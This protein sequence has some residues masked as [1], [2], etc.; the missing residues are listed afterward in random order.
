MKRLFKLFLL[1]NLIFAIT[2]C[3]EP[4]IIYSGKF[5]YIIKY[6]KGMPTVHTVPTD[7]ATL[8][9]ALAHAD[10][11]DKDTIQLHDT[12]V[13]NTSNITVSKAPSDSCL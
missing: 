4:K 13:E 11:S 5:F 1:L 9:A 10:V 12:H 6:Y 3:S 7:F 8:V 2:S